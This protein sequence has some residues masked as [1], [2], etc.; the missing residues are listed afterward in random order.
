MFPLCFCMGLWSS[1]VVTKSTLPQC[2]QSRGHTLPHGTICCVGVG[3]ELHSHAHGAGVHHNHRCGK[4]EGL[5]YR[6]TFGVLTLELVGVLVQ[7]WTNGVVRENGG[8]Y[9]R[10]SRSTLRVPIQ[11][12]GREC[13][14]GMLTL[15]SVPTLL[16][17]AC[18]TSTIMM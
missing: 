15:S 2:Q 6:V 17:P 9:S 1:I 5:W 10:W 11:A 16:L 7:R 3:W 4:E 12:I 18:S 14:G 13:A 8:I